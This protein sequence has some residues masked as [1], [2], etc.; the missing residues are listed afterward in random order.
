MANKENVELKIIQLHYSPK[1]I[2]YIKV[3]KKSEIESLR[4][5]LDKITYPKEYILFVYFYETIKELNMYHVYGQESGSDNAFILG[6][7]INTYITNGNIPFVNKL[8]IKGVIDSD[9]NNQK[10]ELSK[11]NEMFGGYTFK[12]NRKTNEIIP[13]FS[14]DGKLAK[15]DIKRYVPI[16][17]SEDEYIKDLKKR[18]ENYGYHDAKC[19]KG[20]PFCVHFCDYYDKVING[21]TFKCP[22]NHEICNRMCDYYIDSRQ[23]NCLYIKIK[24][25]E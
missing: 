13:V 23:L 14:L 18:Y 10:V 8:S 21:C 25:I 3:K 9:K 4:I 5:L 16:D 1:V 22:Y 2:E 17:K 11:L 6:A 20:S 19:P 12:L 7:L 24:R 15:L